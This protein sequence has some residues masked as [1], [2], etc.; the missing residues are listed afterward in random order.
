MNAPLTGLLLDWRDGDSEA[1]R[2]L[3]PLIYPE[4]KRLAL[5]QLRR[6]RSGFPLEPTELVHEA[7]IR[8]AAQQQP[9]WKNRAHFYS[10]A[11]RLMRQILVDQARHRQ[12]IKR[13]A[14]G[15]SVQLDPAIGAPPAVVHMLRLEQAMKTLERADARKARI[16]ELHYF[17]GLGADE[18]ATLY[19][20]SVVT[21]RRDLRMA[22]ASLRHWLRG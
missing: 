11:A 7:W 8:L 16:V 20:L 1:A 3:A 2:Q 5:A 22:A 17:A 18:I 21:V 15:T 4:L 12:A 6:E 14:G 19:N 13:G 10:I 9:Q